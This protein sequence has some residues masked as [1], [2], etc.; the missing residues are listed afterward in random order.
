[1][2][3]EPSEAVM[4]EKLVQREILRL[5]QVPVPEIVLIKTAAASG[6]GVGVFS[7]SFNPTTTAHVALIEGAARTFSLDQIVALAGVSNADKQGYDCPLAVRIAML[8]LALGANDKVSIGISSSPFF[9][10]MVDAISRVI[11]QATSPYFIVGFDTF[12]RILDV[13]GRYVDRYCTKFADRC[14][15]LAH[16]LSTSYLIVA[17]RSGRGASEIAGIA[18]REPLITPDRVLHLDFPAD[19]GEMSASEVRNRIRSGRE[20]AGLVP[21][22]VE[23]YIHRNGLYAA[24]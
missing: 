14:Q 21:A 5:N 19:L 7:S 8:E 11:P 24:D 10:D 2:K 1:M 12:V 15:A 16:L 6:P 23:D 4:N 18:A 13:D 22:A 9:V 17:A 20:I 3:S